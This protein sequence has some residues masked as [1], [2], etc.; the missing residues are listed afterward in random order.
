MCQ[1]S[2]SPPTKK[3]TKNNW[4]YSTPPLAGNREHTGACLQG[5]DGGVP[6]LARLL[7]GWVAAAV[8]AGGLWE[9]RE[10]E[11]AAAGLVGHRRLR[12]QRAAGRG[13]SGPLCQLLLLGCLLLWLL[14]RTG[15]HRSQA[16]RGEPARP[17]RAGRADASPR[18]H[19]QPLGG[20]R[21]ALAAKRPRPPAPASSST[22]TPQHPSSS[23]RER[24]GPWLPLQTKASP[25]RSHTR[26][27]G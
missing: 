18:P 20:G 22:Q 26:Q 17:N 23:Q 7:L 10:K 19:R 6:G 24:R 4:C 12:A 14:E 15:V 9:E 25:L 1:L 8:G 13:L 11:A 5:E 16:G 27:P 2:A 21:A 3:P